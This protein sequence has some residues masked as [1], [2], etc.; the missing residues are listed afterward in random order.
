[1]NRIAMSAAAAGLLRSL[2]A[3]AA[4]PRDRILLTD[5]HSTDWQSLTLIGE[6]HRLELRV[7][8]PEASAAVERMCDGLEDAEFQI[9]RQ[10]VADIAVA[11]EPSRARDGS[12]CIVIEALT[13][14]E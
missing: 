1:V 10:I 9:P 12:I 2:I 7:V 13:V 4:V 8:G 6:R 5:V 11:G 3:R 14:E